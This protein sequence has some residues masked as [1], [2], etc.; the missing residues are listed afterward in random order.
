MND[1]FKSIADNVDDDLGDNRANDLLT[2]LWRGTR[3]VPRSSQVLT[4]CHPP[5]AVGL[6][7]RGHAVGVKPIDLEFKLAHR[8][9][10][11]VPSPLQ[12]T[13][14]QAVLGIGRVILALRSDGLVA[15]LL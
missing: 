8:D 11:L 12:L 3:A 13:G 5:R 10:A 1:Q 2:R 7:Q 9:Q 6:G 15:G 14:D 4:E